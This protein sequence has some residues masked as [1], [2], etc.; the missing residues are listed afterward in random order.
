[1]KAAL[2]MEIDPELND[3]AAAWQRPDAV[4]RAPAPGLTR[5]KE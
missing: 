5:A 3:R 4:L 1:V 2:V